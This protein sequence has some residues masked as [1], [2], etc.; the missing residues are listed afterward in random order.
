MGS[1]RKVYLNFRNN[2]I[3]LFKNLS[4]SESLWKIPF[5]LLLDNITAFK[6]LVKGDID[7]FKSIEHAHYSFIRWIC[8]KRKK[9]KYPKTKL[10]HLDGVYEGSVVWQYFINKKKTFYQIIGRKK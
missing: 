8:I 6:A 4:C 3:M 5:R 1:K 9:E 10:R 2:L 7:T